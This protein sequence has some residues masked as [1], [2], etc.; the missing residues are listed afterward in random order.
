AAGSYLIPDLV[1]ISQDYRRRL[2][3]EHP[4]GLE[5]LTEPLPLVVEVWSPSTGTY[6]LEVKLPE[7]QRRGDVEI[8]LLHPYQ[9]WLR[10]WRRQPD[11]GYTETLFTGDAVIEPV[12]LPSVRIALAALFE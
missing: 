7:Y 4:S 5:I 9:R 3:R 2:R 12:A 11:G 10:A 1:V 8:W 6:D